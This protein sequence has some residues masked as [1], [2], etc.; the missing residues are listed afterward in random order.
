MHLQS[1]IYRKLDPVAMAYYAVLN[2]F[3][4]ISKNVFL[5]HIVRLDFFLFMVTVFS[6]PGLSLSNPQLQH[7]KPR[8][9]FVTGHFI[10]N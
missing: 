10:N 5:L 4:L 7:V 1:T 6:L 8:I 9:M 3:F 2:F